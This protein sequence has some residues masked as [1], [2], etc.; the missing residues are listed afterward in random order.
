[1]G[2]AK[3]LRPKDGEISNQQQ[4][5]EWGPKEISEKRKEVCDTMNDK[6]AAKSLRG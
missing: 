5:Y 6:Q 2:K 1:M 3:F 4:N